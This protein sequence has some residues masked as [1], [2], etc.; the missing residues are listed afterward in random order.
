ML[1]KQRHEH[2][3]DIF[4]D[5]KLLRLPDIIYLQT[6]LFVHKSL[7]SSSIVPNFTGMPGNV[8]RRSRDSLV[9]LCRTSHAKQNILSRGAKIWNNLPQ[10]LKTN[11]NIKVFKSELMQLLFS[12]YENL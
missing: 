2:T 7:H 5:L 4:I 6:N 11:E 3:Q 1:L 8:T 9:T 12:T 10:H